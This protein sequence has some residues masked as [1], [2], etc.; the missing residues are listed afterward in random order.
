MNRCFW[1]LSVVL[2]CCADVRAEDGYDAWLRYPLVSDGALLDSYRSNIS[3]IVPHSKGLN[4]AADELTRGLSGLL[5]KLPLRKTDVTQKGAIVLYAA[6]KG[7]VPPSINMRLKKLAPDGYIISHASG[8]T[9]I[10][11]NTSRGVLY[12]SFH[13]LRLLQTG[14][15]VENLDISESPKN[16]LRVVN[17]WDNPR[18]D[19]ER[20]YAGGS[21]FKWDNLPDIDPRYRD[22]A[23]LLASIGVNGCVVNNVNTAK[24]GLTGWKLITTEYLPKAAA[25]ANVFREYGVQ[26]YISVNFTSPILIDGLDTADPLDPKVRKWWKDKADEI[27]KLI[28]DFGGFLVKADS[29][30]EPGPYKYGRNHADGAN[31]LAA[32]L[33]P[34]GGV[35]MWRAF[36]YT[37]K[38]L[39][40]AMQAYANFKPI[41]G[42]FADNALV[43]IKNGPMDFQVREPVSPLFG[44]MPDTNLMIELQVTQEY[45]GHST[46]LCYLVPQWK[47]ILGFD[48]HAARAGSTV[49]RIVDG[50]LHGYAHSG[51]AG[52]ANIGD[53]RNWTGHHLAQANTYG[54]GRLAWNP[55]LSSEEITGEWV[56]MTFGHDP[57]VVDT[58]SDML[59]GSWRTYELYTSPLG[60]GFMCGS[61][62]KSRH[63]YDP[64]PAGRRSKYHHADK[65]GVGYDRTQ[66]TGTGYTGQYHPPVA[67]KFES[68]ETCPDDLLL[69]FHH[70]PYTHRLHSGK[71]VIQHIYDSHYD[72]V[73]RAKG[74]REAWKSLEGKIDDAR[75]AHVLNRFDAQIDHAILW[76]DTINKYFFE[77]SGI[78]DKKNRSPAR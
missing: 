20:G 72:G 21:I 27:Y 4:V 38:K 53:D 13:F 50:S 9:V 46:H 28:P 62:I 68:V 45:T 7:P 29:E 22:Y 57:E 1:M 37:N 70:V 34:H 17:H 69:F 47:D 14:T 66:V 6:D 23:R 30:G 77:M 75:F 42:E 61:K 65:R 56:K 2:L 59:L 35:V 60:T 10:A 16:A 48:T 78:P 40:R 12:G 26:M 36:V 33:E 3:S 32:A 51:M 24:K 44:G 49:D 63:H 19:V 39:D 43:Q 52:V 25:L 5:G 41:D 74:Y 71:T 8:K 18:G 64:D 76:R 31:T 11:G 67:R 58:I 73:N 54:Y 15:P 55:T